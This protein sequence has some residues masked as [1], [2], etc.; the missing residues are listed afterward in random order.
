MRDRPTLPG[1]SASWSG[2]LSLTLWCRE[3]PRLR[4]RAMTLPA[5]ATPALVLA[6]LGCA[7]PAAAAVYYVDNANLTCSNAGPGTETQPYCTISAAAAA[8]NG[9]GVVLLVKAGIY[10]EQVTV[11]A[12][13]TS[14]N[15]FIFQAFGGPVVLDGSDDFSSPSQWVVYSQ[16]VYRAAGVTWNAQQVF[17]DGARLQRST[18]APA[19]LP[20]SS[21]TWV[22]GEGLYVNA[23][24]G[25]PGTHQL[26]V[27]RRNY[28]FNIF[29]KSWVA[30]D[31]FEI[32]RTE[33]RGINIQN[34]C[35]DLVVS[36]NRV[37]FANSY[38]IQ[39]VNGVN[40]LID[41]NV[42][43]DCILHGIGLTA[44]ANGCVV[45]NNESFRNADPS[46]RRSNGIHLFGASNNT[47]FGNRLHDNQ[48]SG[49]HLDGGSG[50][51]VL[52]NKRS[53]NNGDHGYDH[54][55][56]GGTVHVNDVAF[57]NVKDGFSIED[58]SPDTHLHNCI[59]IDNG[60]ATN[61]FDLWVDATSSAGFVSDYNIFWNSTPQPPIK[62]VATPY[63][64]LAGYQAASGQDAHTLQ[65]NPM[66]LN[67]AAGDFLPMAGSPAIDAA[68]SAVPH[69]PATDALGSPRVDAPATAN[70]GSGPVPYADR[71]ALEFLTDQAPVVSAPA[72]AS[73]PENSLLT[74]T[75]TAAD[76]D[77]DPIG[78]LTAG[79]LPQGATF[80]P[81]PGNATGLLTWTP[82]ASAIGS[83]TVTFTATNALAGS[84]TTSITVF[85]PSTS[86]VPPGS[87]PSRPLRPSIAPNPVVDRGDLRF[88]VLRAGKLSVQL[89]DLSG[90]IVRRLMEQASAPA[91]D[92]R[93]HFDVGSGAAHG[94][95]ASGVYFFRIQAT[96]GNASERFLILRR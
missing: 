61:E 29:S 25:N 80:A 31:G 70:T 85:E 22:S 36:H 51:C 37:S 49:L 3:K 19:S 21:F 55:Q 74:V 44:G 42:V 88:A 60:F 2:N 10:R 43:S 1:R 57:G 91:G 14:G 75:V 90:R 33:N 12:S 71:G 11:P 8:H 94:P 13:G 47:L 15:P 67:A 86:D 77:G 83:H 56:S 4:P 40:L 39:S 7:T 59:A 65:A 23:G 38:G 76:P 46:V 82:S 24:G 34:G 66:F 62:Y 54:L 89:C 20:E 78:S 18:S 79:G 53:W 95:L 32:T 16:G 6:L 73:V 35:T 87:P 9:P 93:L 48:D 17:M 69:F 41:Q 50:N 68:N 28:G 27:G 64:T 52:Y 26:M 96:E 92:Y 81:G 63:L 72:T 45:R 30:F 5:V 84:D 58:N